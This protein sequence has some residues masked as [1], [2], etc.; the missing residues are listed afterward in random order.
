MPL[1]SVKIFFESDKEMDVKDFKDL[2]FLI[3]EKQ[4][5]NYEEAKS[6]FEFIIKMLIPLRTNSITLFSS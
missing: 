2:I 5:L 6:C 4:V 1:Y 3:T